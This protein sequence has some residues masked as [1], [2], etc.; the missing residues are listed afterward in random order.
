M[1]HLVQLVSAQTRESSQP[2]LSLSQSLSLSLYSLPH[3]KKQEEEGKEEKEGEIG[4]CC[5]GR[6]RW[7]SPITSS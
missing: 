1:A 3:P 6:R 5:S 7:R 4:S 2:T